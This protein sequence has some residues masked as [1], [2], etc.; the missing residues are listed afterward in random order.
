MLAHSG[1]FQPAWRAFKFFIS[2]T[3]L[4]TWSWQC[5]GWKW[6]N[7][8]LRLLW[9][10]KNRNDRR[11]T[12]TGVRCRKVI[13]LGDNSHVEVFLMSQIIVLQFMEKINEH[14]HKDDLFAIYCNTAS[15]AERRLALHASLFIQLW[16]TCL[17][18][19]SSSPQECWSDLFVIKVVSHYSSMKNFCI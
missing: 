11:R 7:I 16:S 3:K 6:V 1:Y 17:V 15:L 18:S 13:H 4:S 5:P 2:E 10:R 19:L 14:A 12:K 8:T 9:Q